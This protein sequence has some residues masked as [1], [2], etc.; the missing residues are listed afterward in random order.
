MTQKVDME[1][2]DTLKL[3]RLNLSLALLGFNN[4]FKTTVELRNDQVQYQ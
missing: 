2:P 3:P 4:I 1:K